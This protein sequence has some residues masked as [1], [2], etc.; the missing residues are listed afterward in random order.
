M[1]LMLKFFKSWKV[2]FLDATNTYSIGD[3]GSGQMDKVIKSD[4]LAERRITHLDQDSFG[5][6]DGM[7]VSYSFEHSE[8]KM[9]N[10]EVIDT[11]QFRQTAIETIYLFDGGSPDV[12]V[13][14]EEALSVMTFDK[15][16]LDGGEVGKIGPKYSIDSGVVGAGLDIYNL[17]GGS[18]YTQ[19]FYLTVNGGEISECNDDKY[20]KRPKIDGGGIDDRI[21]QTDTIWTHTEKQT[22]INDAKLS[23]K[24]TNRLVITDDGLYLKDDMAALDEFNNLKLNLITTRSMQTY[25]FDRYYEFAIASSDDDALRRL[26]YNTTD[27][28]LAPA[29]KCKAEIL[30]GGGFDKL[31]NQIDVPIAEFTEWFEEN[32]PFK[33]EMF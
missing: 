5:M 22:I 7:Q 24:P 18:P 17:E 20:T 1:L 15:S 19:R 25:N 26:V 9:L 10:K 16:S 13:S 11:Y 12:E 8:D 31:K 21:Y 23:R 27:E 33:W 3:N 28:I 14:H 29:N 6:R 4:M 32:N 2:Y 30:D